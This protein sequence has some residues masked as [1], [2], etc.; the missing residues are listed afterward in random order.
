MRYKLKSSARWIE[1]Y[2]VIRKWISTLSKGSVIETYQRPN[3]IFI[4]SGHSETMLLLK[5]GHILEQVL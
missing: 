5:Y 3:T 1:S 4:A 2:S